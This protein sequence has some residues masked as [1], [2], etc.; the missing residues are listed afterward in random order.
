[1]TITPSPVKCSK[2]AVGGREP[3]ISE[4]AKRVSGLLW[5]KTAS[6]TILN[7]NKTAKMTFYNLQKRYDKNVC[8]LPKIFCCASGRVWTCVRSFKSLLYREVWFPEPLFFNRFPWDSIYMYVYIVYRRRF[9]MQIEGRVFS[10]TIQD[11]D[12]PDPTSWRKTFKLC[13]R[14]G[15]KILKAVDDVIN[16]V[17]SDVIFHTK[18]LILD[19]FFKTLFKGKN[20]AVEW[21]RGKFDF[22]HYFAILTNF[23]KR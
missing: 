18:K 23:L 21:E 2:V 8:F 10:Q 14:L 22:D 12:F 1:M 16:D 6:D 5:Q 19:P 9:R 13:T 17:T 3:C 20:F 11:T 15:G 4:R 7:T